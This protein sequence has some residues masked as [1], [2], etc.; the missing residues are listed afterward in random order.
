MIRSQSLYPTEL[1]AHAW[2]AEQPD[3]DNGEIIIAKIHFAEKRKRCLVQWLPPLPRMKMLRPW[4]EEFA[5]P[6]FGPF[7]ASI[8]RSNSFPPPRNSYRARFPI[9]AD[10]ERFRDGMILAL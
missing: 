7:V 8:S 4:N 3:G 10:F 5:Q 9:P 2:Q 1:R 6:A